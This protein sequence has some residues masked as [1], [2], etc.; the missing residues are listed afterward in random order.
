MANFV[1]TDTNGEPIA[2]SCP[3]TGFQSLSVCAPVTVTPFAR[4]G[5]TKTKC[6]GDPVVRP[7]QETCPGIKNGSCHF[8]ISQDLCVEVPVVFGAVSQVGDAFVNCI[9]TSEKDICINC[10]YEDDDDND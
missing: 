4:S 3:A 8:T 5:V 6:C 7:G 1:L 2:E 9:R 10:G